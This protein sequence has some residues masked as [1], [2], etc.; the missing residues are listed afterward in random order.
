MSTQVTTH[1][2]DR[3]YALMRSLFE[4][5]VMNRTHIAAIH[6]SGHERMAKKRVQK[7]TRDG[8]IAARPRRPNEP[9]LH[10]LTKRGFLLLQ[11]A[12]HL[13]NYPQLGYEAFRR[14]ID[15]SPFTQAHEVAVADIKS[16]FCKATHGHDWVTVAEF[17]TWPLLFRFR[18]HATDTGRMAWF[19]P[20]PI[21]ESSGTY[22]RPETHCEFLGES[23]QRHLE[24]FWMQCVWERR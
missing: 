17:S 23:R 13:A 11:N 24:V 15:V 10:F 16:A 20:V 12:S 6:F 19:G 2:T 14:R 22:R 1:Y 5:R 3:D 4:S 7:L 8:L 18:S 9:K 21:T